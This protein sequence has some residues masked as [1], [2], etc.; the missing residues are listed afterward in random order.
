MNLLFTWK[1]LLAVAYYIPHDIFINCEFKCWHIN[2]TSGYLFDEKY[3][4]YLLPLPALFLE[5]ETFKPL[6]CPTS[7]CRAL[8]QH[9]A[10]NLLYGRRITQALSLNN[11]QYGS[12][13]ITLHTIY[14]F[15]YKDQIYF[16]CKNS[17]HPTLQFY[18][19]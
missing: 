2:H 12:I 8:N 10:L 7:W 16:V 1:L 3:W 18:H 4:Y 15:F 9:Q 14:I 11:W 17:P 5:K 13:L 19:F 6:I